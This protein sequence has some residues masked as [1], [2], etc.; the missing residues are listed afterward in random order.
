MKWTSWPWAAE[1]AALALSAAV[2]SPALPARAQTAWNAQLTA[3]DS[4]ALPSSAEPVA[5]DA[6]RAVHEIDDPAT[7]DRWIL[8]RDAAHPEGPGRMAL[9]SPARR[10]N[11]SRSRS[12]AQRENPPV[13][14]PALVIHGGDKVIVEEHTPVVDATL[15]A[16]A[17]G[18]AAPGDPFRV[19]LEIGGKVI[20]AVATAPGHGL[21]AAP[22]GAAQPG[23]SR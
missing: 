19:R 18:P 7:G 5:A 3:L 10:I 16:V 4:P 22:T 8:M 20:L 13:T 2:A 1:F 12:A 14:V 6:N 21:V 11:D 17:L 9:V 15:E 23:A